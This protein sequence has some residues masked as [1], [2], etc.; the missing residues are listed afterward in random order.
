MFKDYLTRNT[1]G[2]SNPKT[3]LR[4]AA[5][6]IMGNRIRFDDPPPVDPPPTD[7][8]PTD[9]PPGDPPPAPP[10]FSWKPKLNVD[11]ANSPTMKQYPDTLEGFQ[12]AVKEHLELKKLLGHEKVPIPKGPD[13]TDGWNRFSKAMGIPDKA[14]E[15]GLP[16]SDVP[17]GLKG[18]TFDKQKFAEVVHAHKLTPG[19]AKGLWGAYTDMVKDTYAKAVKTHE[20]HMTQVVNQ[21]KGEMGDAYDGNIELGQLVINKFSGDKDTEDFITSV[22]AKDPRGIKFLAK[23]GGQFAENK[24]GDFGRQRFSLSPEQAQGEIDT[25]TKDKDHPYNSDKF[26]DE[27]RDRAIDYVNSLISIVQKAKG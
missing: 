20:D 14:T 25:I 21:M 27:E 13:D 26:T 7:P 23:V 15:Y 4:N 24:I 12:N 5:L 11:V 6:S 10:E 3:D 19:Q 18:V 1:L 2:L 16:D 8:P 17:E 9:P 22:L